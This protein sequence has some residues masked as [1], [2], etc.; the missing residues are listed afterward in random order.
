MKPISLQLYSLRPNVYAGGSDLPGVLKTVAEIGYKGVEFAGLH[1]SDPSELAK[2][3]SD[4]G[5][6]VSSSHTA[7]PTPENVNQIAET[8]LALGNK[9]AISG[10]GPDAF[11]TIDACKEAA[12]KFNQ[13]AELLKPYDMEFGIHNH[14]WE[15][16][17]IDGTYVYDILMKEA[18][19]LFSELDVY[20]CAFAKASPSETVA[21]H[22]SR[23]P[24]LHIKDGMLVEGQH[25]HTA[26]GSGKVDMHP[27]IKAADPDVLKWVIVELD[28]CE[29]DMLEAVKESY[30]YLT[31]EGLAAG[32]K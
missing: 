6:C 21:R 24:L 1:G 12:E 20:W 32:N 23:I 26:V 13:A 9:R 30:R 14:W 19:D 8:E 27:I 4:L 31:S 10:F 15:F 28:A 5:L 22:K 3:V 29:T 16:D 2:I 18:P 7:L 17:K 25:V 11:K